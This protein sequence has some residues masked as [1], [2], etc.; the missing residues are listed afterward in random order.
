MLHQQV[1]SEK[2]FIT[3]K[4]TIR[5]FQLRIPRSAEKLVGIECGVQMNAVLPTIQQPAGF[6]QSLTFY[7]SR[8]MGEL[9]FQNIGKGN[10]FYS[11]PVMEQDAHVSYANYAHQSD[12]APKCYTHCAKREPV[13]IEIKRDT[14]IVMGMYKD[15]LGVQLNQN[16]QYWIFIHLWFETKEDES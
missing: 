4:G 11:V 16:L 14:A 9:S 8:T 2:I 6:A 5:H 3:Q 1:Q 10:L 13:E 15:L 7:P 12:F